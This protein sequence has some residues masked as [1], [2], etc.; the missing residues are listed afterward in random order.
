MTPSRRTLALGGGGLLAVAILA[1]AA[2]L[3]GGHVAST[4]DALQDAS[5]PWLAMSFLGFLCAF[6]CTVCAWRAALESAGGRLGYG[7]TAARLGV[8]AMVNSF[9]PAKLGD[10]VKITLCSRAL[11]GPGRLWTTGGAYA[12]LTAARSLT[13]AALV[14]VASAT[15]AMP[16]WPAL[17][18]AGGATIVVAA[19]TA[20][21]KLRNHHRIAQLLEGAAALARDRHALAGVALWTTGMQISRVAGT[22]GVAL[23]LGLPHPFLAA[24]VILTALDLVGTIPLTPGSIGIGSGAVAVAL[25]SRGIG[26]VDALATGLAIQGVETLV[27][28]TC[29]SLGLVHLVQPN[30][31]LRRLVQRGALVGASAVLAALLGLVVRG[32][33]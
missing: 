1:V 7:Q 26:M 33:V 10:A 23:A 8:G 13:L 31:R 5:R 28:V 12:A 3:S 30:E 21:R 9:A 2:R 6:A 22:A 27:S 25:A 32:L 24:L 14:I 16:F 11:D 15:G 19:A 4:L 17:V 18:L 29:G 20:S